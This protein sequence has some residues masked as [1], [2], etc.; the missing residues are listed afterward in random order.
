MKIG[1]GGQL[2]LKFHVV[3]DTQTSIFVIKYL[4]EKEK[5]RETVFTLF[6]R[7]QCILNKKR[8]IKNIVT[9][10]L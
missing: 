7:G 10:S 2:R 6:I 1:G 9:P 4:R 5:V 8:R 3:V